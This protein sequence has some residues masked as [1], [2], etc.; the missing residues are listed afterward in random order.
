[1]ISP[2]RPRTV[3]YNHAASRSKPVGTLPT[4]YISQNGEQLPGFAD[5]KNRNPLTL[6]ISQAP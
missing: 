3:N 5:N 2:D 4:N 6:C 1:M